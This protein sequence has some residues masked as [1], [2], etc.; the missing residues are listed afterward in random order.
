MEDDIMDECEL[1]MFISTVACSLAKCCSTDDLTIL[2]AVFSQLGDTLA[3][4]LTKRE[5][6][7]TPTNN[8]ISELNDDN[9][10]DNSKK[11]E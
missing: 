11:D 2:S 7:T 10:S 6:N 8:T 9:N 1:V 3:T 5:L 4:I